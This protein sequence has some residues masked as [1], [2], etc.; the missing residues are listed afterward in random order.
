MSQRIRVDTESLQRNAKTIEHISCEIKKAGEIIYQ[1]M[2]G[3]QDYNGQLTI[4]ESALKAQHNAC[5]IS[6]QIQEIA[7]EAANIAAKFEEV[8]RETMDSFVAIP[9]PPLP[10]IFYIYPFP[11]NL[12]KE[13]SD[14]GVS[15]IAFNEDCLFYRILPLNTPQLAAGMKAGCFP[16]LGRGN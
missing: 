11:M 9:E 12:L 7:G 5:E 13:T 3:L 15:A 2:S 1:N 4:K 16:S 6:D 14:C 8:D 10:A